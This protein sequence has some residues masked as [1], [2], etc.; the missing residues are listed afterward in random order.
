MADLAKIL[1]S[2][3]PGLLTGVTTAGTAIVG[4][5]NGV[6]KQVDDLETRVGKFDPNTGSKS[7]I[8]LALYS[9]QGEVAKMRKEIEGWASNPPTWLIN[10]ILQQ[11]S[12]QSLDTHALED[13]IVRRSI[14]A[15]TPKLDELFRRV[16]DLEGS[17]S[18]VVTM[19][20]FQ[21]H[22]DRRA[23]EVAKVRE[24]V[25]NMQGILAGMRGYLGIEK[26]EVTRDPRNR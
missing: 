17:L 5:F 12:R 7:G 19:E 22:S 3:L 16:N 8:F 13:R 6:K 11:A 25:A 2:V 10:L 26:K 14:E 18:T 21:E 4:F 20:S 9:L 15:M 24:L 23:E 1:E